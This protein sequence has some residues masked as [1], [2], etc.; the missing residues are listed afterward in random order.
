MGELVS[1]IASIP[2]SW[3]KYSVHIIEP[4]LN[5]IAPS[6]APELIRRLAISEDIVKLKIKWKSGIYTSFSTK[7]DVDEPVRIRVYG[8]LAEH[9]L[10]FKNTFLAFKSALQDF[11]S[12]IINNECK[13][14]IEFNQ[15][16]VN[17][18]ERGIR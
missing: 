1:I 11:V 10:V 15:K 7:G 6:D 4:V 8:H 12:G 18:I 13:S 17:L 2:N 3:K 5:M 16:V 9:E 14:P